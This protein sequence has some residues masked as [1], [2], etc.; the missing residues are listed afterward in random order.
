MAA[1]TSLPVQTSL[2]SQANRP[3]WVKKSLGAVS[4]RC[5]LETS[6]GLWTWVMFLIRA[7]RQQGHLS[8]LLPP[9]CKQGWGPM[10]VEYSQAPAL[11]PL[12]VNTLQRIFVTVQAER[13]SPDDGSLHQE[14]DEGGHEGAGG[15]KGRWQRGVHP[16]TPCTI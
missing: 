10:W 3:P 13:P 15:G 1:A 2:S 5:S 8:W 6:H 7:S 9:L 12:L 14:W 11:T 4:V 16:N